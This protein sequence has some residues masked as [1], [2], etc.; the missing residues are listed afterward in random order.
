MPCIFETSYIHV[1]I[2]IIIIIII[3]RTAL[4]E[5]WPSLED[6]VILHP[7]YTS[8]DFAT[9]IFYR[10]SLSALRPTPNL[11]DLLYMYIYICT[12]NIYMFT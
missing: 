3:V 7:V 9:I 4:L 5:P 10:A 6:S 1:I 2:I 8:F 12:E 11:G